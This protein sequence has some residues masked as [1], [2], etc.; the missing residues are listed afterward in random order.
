MVSNYFSCC[1][2]LFATGIVTSPNYPENYPNNFRKTETIQVEQGLVLSLQFTAFII[3]P[4]PRCGDLL[5]IADGDGTILME[6][7]CGPF[8]D[9]SILI[10]GQSIIYD[11][12]DNSSSLPPNITSKSNIVKLM[13]SSNG[14]RTFPGWS[15]NWTAVTPGECQQHVNIAKFSI[16]TV[17]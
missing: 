6:K 12:L 10:G 15:V 7:S 3:E 1:E 17:H 2:R 16:L 13:F 4:H 8:N 9:G 5:K 14:F 11:I